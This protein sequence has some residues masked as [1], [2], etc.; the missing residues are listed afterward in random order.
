LGKN[1]SNAKNTVL[2]E[3]KDIPISGRGPPYSSR[4]VFVKDIY[5]SKTSKAN[6]MRYPHGLLNLVFDSDAV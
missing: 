5:P 3:I 6:K 1:K 2:R 4:I